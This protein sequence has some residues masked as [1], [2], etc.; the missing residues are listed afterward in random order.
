[1]HRAGAGRPEAGDRVNGGDRVN[2]AQARLERRTRALLRAYPAQYR[3][4]RGEEI[5]ATLLE[6]SPPGR[7]FPLARDVW[8][9]AKGGRAARAARN[10]ELGGR[11]SLRL[12]LLLGI[13]LYLIVSISY[14]VAVGSLADPSHFGWAPMATL[15]LVTAAALGPWLG[16]RSITAVT[17]IPAAGLL[18]YQTLHS[19]GSSG[20]Q[21]SQFTGLT[22][23]LITLG[24]LIVLTN[25]R[26][27]L[28]SSWV[29]LPCLP[30]AVLAAGRALLAPFSYTS[31]TV[32]TPAWVLL[33]AAVICW[34]LTDVRPAFGLGIA[35]T[36]QA[37]FWFALDLSE[38]SD[39]RIFGFAEIYS[40]LPFLGVALAILVPSGWLLR[41][42]SA[43]KPRPLLHP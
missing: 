10:R 38:F 1:V 33:L 12:A 28:P 37:L 19:P 26:A 42:Q 39:L 17:A 43:R 34:L 11:A 23:D 29:W 3:R 22:G 27:P 30:L 35:L 21:A 40:A 5:I 13:S 14:P 25:R 15:T 36:L 7:S 18:A 31:D 6:A 16:N 9:L 24:A 2:E 4:D 41:R 20:L 8:A 32:L